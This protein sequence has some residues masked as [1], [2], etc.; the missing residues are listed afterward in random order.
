MAGFCSADSTGD[1]TGGVEESYGLLWEPFLI[2]VD[3]IEVQSL[4][5]PS[6]K[7]RDLWLPGRLACKQAAATAKA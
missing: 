2:P 3:G 1:E 7:Q 5:L 4:N 6:V